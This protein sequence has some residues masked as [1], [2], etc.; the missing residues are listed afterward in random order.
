MAVDLRFHRLKHGL[1]GSQLGRIINCSRHTV[2]NLEAGRPGWWLKEDQA[3]KLDQYFALNGHFKR[4]LRYARLG[5]DPDW[6]KAHVQYEARATEHKIYELGVIPGLLQTPDYARALF[7]SFG[8]K[9]V[10]GQVA[11]RMERQRA[12]F[13]ENPPFLWVIL[14]QP[15][16][17]WL[18]GGP[19]VMREQLTRLLEVAEQPD[20]ILRVVHKSAG[21]HPGLGGAFQIM[22][23]EGADLVYTEAL[24]GGRLVE[25]GS[26]VQAFARRFGRIGAQALTESASLKHVQ[27]AME[28]LR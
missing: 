6:F 17:E 20:V 15:V 11:T 3:V 21:G 1:S 7:R 24:G 19:N 5:H 10:E 8:S 28:T 25:G 9:D 14:A 16:L 2:S 23:V 13:D 12:V 4:L 22:T 26:E 27:Q 18:V